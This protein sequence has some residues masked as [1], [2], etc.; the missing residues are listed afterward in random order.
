M[1]NPTVP[2][3][4][5]DKFSLLQITAS[6]IQGSAIEPPYYVDCSSVLK[7]ATS[8]NVMVKLADDS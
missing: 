5:V 1:D 4:E 7:P 8:G 6:V 2:N 3:N